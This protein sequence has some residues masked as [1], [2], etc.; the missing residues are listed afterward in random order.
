[1]TLPQNRHDQKSCGIPLSPPTSQVQPPS[2]CAIC[3]SRSFAPGR[4]ARH[5]WH[6][7]ASASLMSVHRGHDHWPSAGIA[8][9]AVCFETMIELARVGGGVVGLECLRAGGRETERGL[10]RLGLPSP[11]PRVTRCTEGRGMRDDDEAVES[12]EV[13]D[14]LEAYPL[15]GRSV[16]E[17][18]EADEE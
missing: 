18:M 3:R 6:C 15:P 5:A 2:S 11:A 8:V 16:V 4:S 14:E 17:D 7:S 10:G 12:V 1:M 9:L 13:D